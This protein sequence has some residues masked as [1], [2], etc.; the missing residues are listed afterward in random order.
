MSY[1]N[2][3]IKYQEQTIQDKFEIYHQDNPHVYELFKKYAR[4]ARDR[5]FN[6]FSAKAIFER[7]RWHY[8][9]E[10]S[11]DVFKLN[12]NYTAHYARMLMDDDEA[13]DGF[14]ETRERK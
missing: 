10:T 6:K 1:V 13:F 4:M 3:A 8:M 7:L 12:N 5:G 14:F 9:I 11:G 2:A